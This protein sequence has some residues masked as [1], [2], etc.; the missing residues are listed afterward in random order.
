MS[1][2]VVV[3]FRYGIRSQNVFYIDGY[4]SVLFQEQASIFLIHIP[5][6]SLH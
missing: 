4:N 3:L 2:E 6:L 5:L 1:C